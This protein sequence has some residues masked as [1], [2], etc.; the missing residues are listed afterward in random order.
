MDMEP[1]DSEQV[2]KRLLTIAEIL[3]RK[4]DE[5]PDFAREKDPENHDSCEMGYRE[6]EDRS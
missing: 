1:P 6:P 2:V 5:A 3:L 4:P